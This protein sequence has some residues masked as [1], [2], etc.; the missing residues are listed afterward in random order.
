MY[1]FKLHLGCYLNLSWQIKQH[2]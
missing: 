2:V 1:I